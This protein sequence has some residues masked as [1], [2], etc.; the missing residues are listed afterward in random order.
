MNVKIQYMNIT[1]KNKY[2]A[3]SNVGLISSTQVMQV[4]CKNSEGKILNIL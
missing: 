1:F 2:T 3:Q 4:A